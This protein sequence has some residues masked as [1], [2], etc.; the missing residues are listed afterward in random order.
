MHDIS[1]LDPREDLPEAL[2]ELLDACP[3]AV[4]ASRPPDH[5]STRFWLDRHRM[6]RMLLARMEDGA[7][8]LESAG[9]PPEAGIRAV[10]RDAA[11]LLNEVHGHQKVEELH[12]FPRLVTFEPGL[13]AAFAMLDADH[14]ALD[15]HLKELAAAVA[16]LIRAGPEDLERCI[17]WLQLRLARFGSCLDRHLTDEEDIVLPILLRHG[18]ALE[19]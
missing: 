8:D 1:V 18:V 5:A 13:G 2:R 14:Q 15:L 10:R 12:Y 17:G 19:A 6:F 9:A 11:I 4:W 3:R 7:R 16:E